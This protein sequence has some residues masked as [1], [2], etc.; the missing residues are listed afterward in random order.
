MNNLSTYDPPVRSCLNDKIPMKEK[1]NNL[2]E[3][4]IVSNCTFLMIRYLPDN[5]ANPL[6]VML[7]GLMTLVYLMITIA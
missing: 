3:R 5:Y 4:F 7:T 6:N 1:P 2:Y